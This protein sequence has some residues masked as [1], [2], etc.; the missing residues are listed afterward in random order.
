MVKP[1]GG[2]VKASSPSTAANASDK[3]AAYRAHVDSLQDRLLLSLRDGAWRKVSE[4]ALWLAPRLKPEFAVHRYTAAGGLPD[5]KLEHK[6]GE[7]QKLILR[8]I[9]N[10]LRGRKLVTVRTGGAGEEEV[11]STPLADDRFEADPEFENLLPRAPDEVKKLEERLLVEEPRDPLV[12]WKGHR[13]L[14]DGYTRFRLFALLGRSYPVVEM[15]F[16]DRNAVVAWLYATHYGR[17]SFSPEMKS[18]VRGRQYLARKKQHGGARKKASAQ[19]GHLKT[20][21]AVAAEYGI[22]RN[23]VRRDAAFAEALDKVADC[24]GDEVRQQVL[25]RVARWTRRDVERLARLEKK[26]VQ[27][28]VRVALGLGKRPRFPA[29]AGGQAAARKSVSIPLGKPVEQVRILRKVLGGKGLV[30]LQ[31]AIARLLE[32]QKGAHPG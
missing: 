25:S 32:R 2:A 13:K 17:R 5:K 22:G 23:T 1:P 12:V 30:R 4:V 7:G 28:I 18:Y 15:D 9:L 29:P 21:D 6:S 8:D 20:A 14:V 19:S 24:C 16:P 26:A 31:A 27:E 11:R 3:E 10:T